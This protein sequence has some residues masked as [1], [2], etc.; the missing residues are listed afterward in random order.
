MTLSFWIKRNRTNSGG[1]KGIIGNSSGN[2][3]LRFNDDADGDELRF[4]HPDGSIYWPIN[5]RDVC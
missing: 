3:F 5:F 2:T 1:I 4:Y